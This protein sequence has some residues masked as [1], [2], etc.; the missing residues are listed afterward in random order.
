MF[1]FPTKNYNNSMAN[2][3]SKDDRSLQSLLGFSQ[4]TVDPVKHPD[5]SRSQSKLEKVLFDDFDDVPMSNVSNMTLPSAPTI[6]TVQHIKKN[7]SVSGLSDLFGEDSDSSSF[8]STLT[9][10]QSSASESASFSGSLH[11]LS[12]VQKTESNLL[13]TR[14]DS[15]HVQ[16]RK[17]ELEKRRSSEKLGSVAEKKARP[18]G[19]S[20][21]FSPS[22]T[23]DSKHDIQIPS[24]ISP[25]KQ[26]QDQMR[27]N[28][29]TSNS[30]NNDAIVNVQKLENL[31]PDSRVSE[32]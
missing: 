17:E 25:L 5:Q 29:T 21:L 28:R 3:Q 8:L 10:S 1:N 4:P 19:K 2:K 18:S 22:P 15:P 11:G 24:L 9:Q 20:G 26:E 27:R 12:D 13:G 30:S 7:D 16:V 6:S 31:A 23:Q 14:T 32:R